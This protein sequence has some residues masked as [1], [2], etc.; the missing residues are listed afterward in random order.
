MACWEGVYEHSGD[1]SKCPWAEFY[2]RDHQAIMHALSHVDL[3]ELQ[4]AISRFL[5]GLVTAIEEWTVYTRI[6]STKSP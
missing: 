6:V 5:P 2:W 3:S 4:H 1:C